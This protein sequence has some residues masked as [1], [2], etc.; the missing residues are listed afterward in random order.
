TNNVPKGNH[1]G[2]I[3]RFA[4]KDG[5]AGSLEFTFSTFVPGGVDSRL[6]CPDNIIIDSNE[7]L[8]VTNDISEKAIGHDPY[9]PYGNN[10]LYI[11]PTRGLYQGQVFQ[12]ASA[13]ADAEFT[14]P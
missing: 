7:N 8:W 6:A 5:D 9:R 14:G 2:S 1:L 13:P 4:E 3:A 10:G 12:V 11:V